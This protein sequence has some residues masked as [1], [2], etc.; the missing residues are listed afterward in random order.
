MSLRH[1][2][3]IADWSSQG[4]SDTA[5]FAADNTV[6]RLLPVPIPKQV[7]MARM[8]IVCLVL[9]LFLAECK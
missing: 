1:D 7:T 8:W 2:S 9:G 3:V 5:Y 4:N 6:W